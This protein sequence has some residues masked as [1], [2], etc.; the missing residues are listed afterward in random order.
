MMYARNDS[1]LICAA[2]KSTNTS[3]LNDAFDLTYN[4]K[5]ETVCLFTTQPVPDLNCDRGPES[6]AVLQQLLGTVMS[7]VRW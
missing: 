7:K 1:V 3:L 2:M 6:P 4:D 5:G